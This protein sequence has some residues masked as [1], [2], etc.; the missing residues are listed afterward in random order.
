MDQEM[1]DHRLR[2]IRVIEQGMER[3]DVSVLP[4][5]LNKSKGGN[6]P[7]VAGDMRGN[8]R[9]EGTLNLPEQPVRIKTNEL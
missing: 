5:P 7:V 9:K 8:G 1:P 4:Y 3:D 2:S 6:A